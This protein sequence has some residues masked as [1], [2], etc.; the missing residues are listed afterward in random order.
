[1]LERP[2]I[3]IIDDA[4]EICR[5]YNSVLTQAGF[6]VLVAE[7]GSK[8][9]FKA[10]TEQPRLIMLDLRLPDADGLEVLTTLRSKDATKTTPIIVFTG[11]ATKQKVEEALALGADAFIYKGMMPIKEMVDK[12]RSLIFPSETPSQENSPDHEATP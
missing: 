11:S 4:A 9:I 3:L 2:K 12:I 5:F 7:D 1:M 6:K 10:E 8:G